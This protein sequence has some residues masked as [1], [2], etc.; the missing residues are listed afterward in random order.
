V[1]TL[2]WSR[3]D[4]Q[5]L[6]TRVVDNGQGILTIRDAEAADSGAYTCTG[7]NAFNIA[8]DVAILEVIGTVTPCYRSTLS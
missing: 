4:G 2:A 7:S 3:Q 6:P 1:Y 5:V 8:T